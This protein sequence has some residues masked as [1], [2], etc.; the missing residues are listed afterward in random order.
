MI[1]WSWFAEKLNFLR[2][3]LAHLDAIIIALTNML[4]FQQD[5]SSPG[6]IIARRANSMA[7]S[8]RIKKIVRSRNGI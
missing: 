2:D 3:G 8:A 4:V 7:A 6:K 5:A 1:L